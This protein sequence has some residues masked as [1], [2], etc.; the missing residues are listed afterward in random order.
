VTYL[1]RALRLQPDLVDASGLL[2]TAYVRLG[3]SAKAIPELQTATSLDPLSLMIRANL[4]GAYL[5]AGRYT[6]AIQHLRATLDLDPTYG[7]AHGGLA[8]TFAEAHRNE[9][10]MKEYSKAFP[11]SNTEALAFRAYLYA[12]SGKHQE[13]RNL[14]RNMENTATLRALPIYNQAALYAVIG[15]ADRAFELLSKSF[16][17]RCALADLQL[18]TRFREFHG[19]PRYQAVLRRIGFPATS[20]AHENAALSRP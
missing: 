16:D 13:A 3:E 19:D 5:S 11:V 6:E 10:A 15:D 17:D 20:A 8:I 9:D 14:V 12:R 7:S 4:G 2:G 1:Q 18:D